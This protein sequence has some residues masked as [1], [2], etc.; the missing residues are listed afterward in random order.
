MLELLFLQLDLLARRGDVHQ[1]PAD[2]G[3]LIEH[4]L[5]GKIEHLVGLLGG[6]ERLVGFGLHY[7][8]G[9]LEKA[10]S[11]LLLVMMDG[12][13]RLRC[14]AGSASVAELVPAPISQ[15]LPPGVRPADPRIRRITTTAVR[16]E[17]SRQR[18]VTAPPGLG[19]KSGTAAFSTGRA[20]K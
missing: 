14:R 16:S 4:L 7:F 10:H 13:R 5:V 17:T 15:R 3:D 2:L 11:G 9:P 1:P 19:G 18:A 8:V 12:P 6:V 20:G